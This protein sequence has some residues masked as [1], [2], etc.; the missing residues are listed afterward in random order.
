VRG[1]VAATTV[2]GALL[3]TGGCS[4]DESTKPVTIASGT[5]WSLVT[6]HNA[7][8][9]LCLQLRDDTG[10]GLSG[11]CGGWESSNPGHD[12]DPYMSGLGPAGS[13][14]AF[15][16]LG[17][18]V[19]SVEATAPGRRPLTTPARPLPPG[20]GAPKFF[21]LPLPDATTTWTYTAKDAAGSPRP[22][23]A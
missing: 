3:A 8:G 1:F 12:E 17:S 6:F 15:G 7:A 10:E 16:P 23:G 14:F 11:G 9:D 20:A 22:L 19:V 21:V 5:A 2:L 18:A 13:E 4:A